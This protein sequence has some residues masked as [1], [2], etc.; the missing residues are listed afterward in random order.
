MERW[1]QI[2]N[3]RRVV[4]T[5]TPIVLY[6]WKRE[7]TDVCERY[8]KYAI[9]FRIWSFKF[10]LSLAIY[11]VSSQLTVTSEKFIKATPL[12]ESNN[13]LCFQYHMV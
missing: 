10:F 2:S 1:W 9:N 13:R 5:E 6:S 4:A 11:S 3:A 8:R 12:E 7:A